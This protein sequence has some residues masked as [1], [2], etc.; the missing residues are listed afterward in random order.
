MLFADLCGDFLGYI[1]H[2]RGLARTTV[3]CYSAWLAHFRRWADSET[4]GFTVDQ[5]L[6]TPCLRRYLYSMSA[7]GIRPRTIRNAFAPLRSLSQYALG[8]GL[9]GENPALPL[10]MPKKDAASRPV[11]S[12]GEIVAL[13]E[14]S[15]RQH[16]PRRV[17]LGRAVV[18]VLVYTGLRFA[19]LLNLRVEDVRFGDGTLLVA[20]GKGGKSRLLYPAP[21]C[22]H[23]LSEWVSVR[24]S[25]R[26]CHG[27]LWAH[28]TRR[29]VGEWGM[30]QMLEEIKA[31]AGIADHTNILPHA[32]RRAFATRLTETK[33]LMA[34]SH[35]LG[36]QSPSTT[37]AYLYLGEDAA[38][39]MREVEMVPATVLER[40]S[41][42][43]AARRRIDVSTGRTAR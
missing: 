10:K 23:A 7:R 2:E 11:V 25:M 24:S 22:I 35:A 37:F 40:R 29:R 38:K 21:P 5:R 42:A 32:F 31:I 17:A 27:W 8:F 20:N 15:E 1:E 34:A 18:S 39:A 4:V 3:K 43:R 12:S 19:E 13:L 16:D 41:A 28:D 26:C 9:I 36:H 14:A 6:N 33:G 30:R